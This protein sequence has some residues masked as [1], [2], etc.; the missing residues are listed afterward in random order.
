LQVVGIPHRARTRMGLLRGEADVEEAEQALILH[1]LA[2]F[3]TLNKSATSER[4]RFLLPEPS[5][6]VL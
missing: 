4:G 2:D 1:R 3:R 5:G 6:R